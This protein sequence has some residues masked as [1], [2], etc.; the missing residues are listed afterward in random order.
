[1]WKLASRAL[2]KAVY[3]NLT[4]YQP[5]MDKVN[6]VTE[7]PSKD[8][9]YPYVVLGDQ[10]SAPF[11]TKSSFGEEITM[12]FHVWGGTTRAE[13]QDISSHVLE[14][15]SSMPLVFEGFTFVAK[16][17]VL[18]QIITDT[19]GVTKHGIIKVRFTINNN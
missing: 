13:A 16:K 18:A 4:S 12:D 9:P 5:L 14:A 1:M 17:L 8:D 10:S 19:D 11:E 2:Q 7:T 6:Q 3:Q 15:L